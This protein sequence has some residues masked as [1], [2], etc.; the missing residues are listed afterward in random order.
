MIKFIIFLCAVLII[1]VAV[2][3]FRSPR[4]KGKQGENAVSRVLGKT[5]PGEQYIINNLLFSDDSGQSCEIDHIFI[6]RRGIWVIET[7]NYSGTIY[8]GEDQREWTQVLAYGNVKNK[9]YNPVKQN[10]THIYHLSKYLKARNIFI[11]VV[12]FLDNA[13]V[14]NVR[15]ASVITLSDLKDIKNKKTGITLSS[16]QMKAFY[17]KLLSLKDGSH[18]SRRQH[19]K[20]I[21]KKQK[22]LK[23]GK[24]PRC[25]AKLVLRNGEYGKFYGCSNFPECTFTKN[26]DKSKE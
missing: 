15:S 12:V 23:R 13:D 8:G 25:G 10:Q 4:S 16:E 24:C 5:I 19:V 7:K 22:Q 1:A 21:R 17:D 2:I 18:L 26:I 9:L 6:N 14:T 11:N 3:I 20:N